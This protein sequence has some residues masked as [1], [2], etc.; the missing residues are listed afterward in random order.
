MNSKMLSRQVTGVVS[1]PIKNTSMIN[2]NSNEIIAHLA[3]KWKADALVDV[4]S[5]PVLDRRKFESAVNLTII[6]TREYQ[7]VIVGVVR[8]NLKVD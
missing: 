4:D 2:P 8:T 3:P 6:N 1:T 7:D 5:M